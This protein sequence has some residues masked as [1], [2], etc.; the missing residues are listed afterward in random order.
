MIV[1]SLDSLV[2]FL[3]QV[4]NAYIRTRIRV[5]HRINSSKKW[6]K[7]PNAD[8]YSKPDF[9]EALLNHWGEGN[10]WN[11]IKLLMAPCRGKIL[12]IACGT[13][14]VI[15]QLKM[16]DQCSFYGCDAIN[17]LIEK[18]RQK[19]V[20]GGRLQIC[21]A[22]KLSFSDLTFDFSYS[23]GSFHCMESEEVIAAAIRESHRVTKN[24]FF[25]QVATSRKNMDEGLIRFHQHFY[26]N[27]VNWWRDKC[28]QVYAKVFVLDSQW[29]DAVSDGKW[30]LCFKN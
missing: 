3:G 11:E 13:G 12:D 18:A 23:I 25:F 1:N 28:L 15:R 24:A 30:F 9:S 7:N 21:N 8:I 22:A 17:I 14:E 16:F 2:G 5:Q 4:K 6:G 20:P 26:N 19:G 29:R 27:S 10:V